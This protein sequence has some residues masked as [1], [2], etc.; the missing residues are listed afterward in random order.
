MSEWI[1]VSPETLPKPGSKVLATYV[2]GLGK[3]RVAA[4]AFFTPEIIAEEWEESDAVPGWYE[5]TDSAEECWPLEC[6]VTH[7]QPLP[8]PPA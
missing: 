1:P 2:N 7:W 4:A 6:S 8:A 3:R 5:V